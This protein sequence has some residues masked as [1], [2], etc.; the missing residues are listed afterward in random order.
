MFLIFI[1]FIKEWLRRNVCFEFIISNRSGP[2]IKVNLTQSLTASTLLHRLVLLS[3]CF[4]YPKS[5]RYSTNWD[6]KCWPG[7]EIQMY[8]CS[9]WFAFRTFVR[10][11]K[12]GGATESQSRNG[13]CI[14]SS[15][16]G[17]FDMKAFFFF[18]CSLTLGNLLTHSHRF[19]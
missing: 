19:L 13:N 6:W 5:R 4:I 14:C 10:K 8:S 7:S 11:I 15:P 12:A 16:S 9:P 18:L 2:L 1:P 17:W 3:V